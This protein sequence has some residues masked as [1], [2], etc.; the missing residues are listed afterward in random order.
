[1]LG[2][3]WTIA[4]H[5]LRGRERGAQLGY[6]IA[7]EGPDLGRGP[8]PLGGFFADTPTSET[9]VILLHGLGG[10]PDSG[11][12]R[13]VARE[14]HAQDL[15]V[16]RL[17]LRGAEG[18]ATD[19]YHA[20]L[21]E[22]LDAVLT[23]PALARFTHIAV[24]GFSLGGH[25]ALRWAMRPGDP[26]VVGVAA[27]CPPLDLAAVQA[28]LDAPARSL[29]RHHILRGLKAMFARVHALRPFDIEARRV[30]AISSLRE[31]DAQVVVPRY[32][33]GSVNDYYALASAGPR[34]DRLQIPTL[35][36]EATRDPMIP[37]QSTAPHLVRRSPMLTVRRTRAGGHVGFPPWLDL[38]AGGKPGLEAQ[39]AA[40]VRG[41]VRAAS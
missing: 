21:T 35:L 10:S 40:W 25:I 27:I 11:Y 18:D 16:L 7:F 30:R 34:L 8:T 9:L 20:A 31:W 23:R 13:A 15:A 14:L 17:G 22:D 24:V 36:V 4:P 37:T 2:H 39:L 6:P 1:M 41:R 28:H 26:R 29:Y 33:F 3:F 38:G 19:L 32:G 12:I 5:L